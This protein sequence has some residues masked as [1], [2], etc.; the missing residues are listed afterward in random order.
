MVEIINMPY[1]IRDILILIISMVIIWI[2]L[3][4]GKKIRK[5]LNAPEFIKAFNLLIVSFL[6]ITLAQVIGVLVRT[7]ILFY[8]RYPYL[9]LRAILLTAGA[10]C[11]FV[12]S[13]LVYLPFA[14]NR[15]KVIRI[16]TEPVFAFK[17]G[18]YYGNS[19][20][21]Y[22]TFVK[23]VKEEKIPG[24][25]VARNPP[26]VFRRRLGLK[27]I[28]VLWISKVEH[29]DAIHPTRLAYLLE[30]LK[31]FLESADIDKAVLIDGIEY[32]ILENGEKAILKFITKLKDI[33]VLNRGI[34]I[35]SID[36][37]AVDEKTYGLLTSELNPIEALLAE[38]EV[39]K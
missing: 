33:A 8:T 27:L 11:L 18:A 16:T 34:I 36:K 37:G 4:T 6:F 2:L 28:P 39:K 5:N 17:Y 10:L 24:I 15:Y 20:E 22:S 14:K 21:C 13:I 19:E 23:L 26:E 32:L 38:M 1:F 30:H 31:N 7:S 12:S 9:H 25:A 35:I 3:C 29:E